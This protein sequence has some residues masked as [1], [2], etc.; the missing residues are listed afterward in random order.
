MTRIWCA[1]AA[2]CAV[3]LAAGVSPA[4]GAFPGKN[5]KI[6][7]VSDRRAAT[8]TSGRWTRTGAGSPT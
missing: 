2:V 1:V 8:A 6:A 7:F 5:G 3:A 4:H